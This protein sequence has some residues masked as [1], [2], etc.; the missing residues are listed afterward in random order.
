MYLVHL[1]HLLPLHLNYLHFPSR[2]EITHPLRT[3]ERVSA[4]S[5]H[6]LPLA[7]QGKEGSSKHICFDYWS[8]RFE[9]GKVGCFLSAKVARG[10]FFLE[11][12][13]QLA[14]SAQEIY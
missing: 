12:S 1:F 3:I 10:F 11:V 7:G 2:L 14:T 5:S 9:Y 13:S 8:L 4:L 6:I